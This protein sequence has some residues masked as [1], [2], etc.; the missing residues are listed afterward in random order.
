MKAGLTG[1]LAG[2]AETGTLALPGGAGRMLSASLLPEVHLAVLYAEEICANL[3]EV[4][5]AAGDLPRGRGRSGQR[6]IAHRRYR[7][8]PDHRRARAGRIAGD[9]RAFERVQGRIPAHRSDG[10]P[11]APTGN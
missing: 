11:R 5:G 2:A 10:Q 9:L 8:D 1:A 4:L 6:P 3:A 7:D